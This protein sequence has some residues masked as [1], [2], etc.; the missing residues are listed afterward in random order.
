MVVGRQAEIVSAGDRHR[1]IA[2][3]AGGPAV[4]RRPAD[5][6]VSGVV[7]VLVLRPGRRA[8][9]AH[10]ATA[11]QEAHPRGGCS[12]RLRAHL[13]E[14]QENGSLGRQLAAMPAQE[15]AHARRTGLVGPDRTSWS[16]KCSSRP[17]RRSI[18]CSASA[19]P[20]ALSFAPATVSE[21]A[22]S[23]RSATA[24]ISATVGTSWIAESAVPSRPATRRPQHASRAISASSSGSSGPTRR[25]GRAGQGGA[26]AAPKQAAATRVDVRDQHECARLRSPARRPRFARRADPEPANGRGDAARVEHGGQ[27]GG[28][29]HERR[30]RNRRR[31]RQHAARHGHRGVDREGQRPVGPGGDRLDPRLAP[32]RLEAPSKMSGGAALGVAAR[33]ARLERRQRLDLEEEVDLSAVRWM[34]SVR[35][36]G[37]NPHALSGNGF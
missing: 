11:G 5:E 24:T 14:A 25:R 16:S 12:A 20:E 3:H 33:S 4:A 18:I 17:S 29:E 9:P 35:R 6:P 36:V 23:S 1:R 19:A 27:P 26:W 13:V 34:R 22:M 32:E 2:G 28:D 21:S 37:L 7:L 8:L 30:A 15:S 10:R 31:D